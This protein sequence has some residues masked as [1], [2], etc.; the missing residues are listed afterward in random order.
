MMGKDVWAFFLYFEDDFAGRYE[1]QSIR[2]EKNSLAVASG[3]TSA[4]ATV[5]AT[6]GNPPKILASLTSEGADYKSITLIL[7]RAIG[8]G[9]LQ[10]SIQQDLAVLTKGG[11]GYK[12]VSWAPVN[13]GG[14][15]VLWIF[16]PSKLHSQRGPLKDLLEALGAKV[17]RSVFAGFSD[18]AG[19]VEMDDFIIADDPTMS[20]QLEL[21]LEDGSKSEINDFAALEFT[22]TT[23]QQ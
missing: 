15:E 22:K 4:T 20:Y 6:G 1:G 19:G 5:D 17:N 9:S 18:Y 10:D 11:E 13:R 3:S 8:K 21:L 7:D 23:S 12:E 14:L 2:C 16:S